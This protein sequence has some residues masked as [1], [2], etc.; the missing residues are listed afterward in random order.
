MLT[1][2]EIV[3]WAK[4]INLPPCVGDEFAQDHDGRLPA[5]EQELNDWGDAT[6]RRSAEYE[7]G[8]RCL[9]TVKK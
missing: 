9:G 2:N 8:W 5:T 3:D 4:R 1:Q 6:Y 7:G